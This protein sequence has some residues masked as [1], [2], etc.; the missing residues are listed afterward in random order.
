MPF[1]GFRDEALAFFEG[2][3]ADNTK[4]YWLT[5][6]QTHDDLI[7]A[8]M[9]ALLEEIAPT[10]GKGRPFRAYRGVRFSVD[11]SPY[12]THIGARVGEDRYVQLRAEGLAAGAGMWEMAHDQLARYRKAV[13]DGASGG[14]LAG[15]VARLPGEVM[16][17]GRVATGP[18]GYPRDH[19]RVDLLRFTG[20]A[21]W[22]SWGAPGWLATP[23][24]REH[25]E[26]FYA[27]AQPLVHWL[28]EHVGVSVLPRDGRR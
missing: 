6:R 1:Q 10:W 14:D 25:L 16:A 19:P 15:I 3:E 4:A 26:V 5:H 18:R 7:R 13:A 12:K 22:T 11:K 2:L 17:H 9:D 27:D 21:V 24:A 23:A 20:L 28:R 8:E